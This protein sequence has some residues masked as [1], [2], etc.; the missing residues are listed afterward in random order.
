MSDV[1]LQPD[2]Q[3]D[4]AAPDKQDTTAKPAND[5]AAPDKANG[6][7][8]AAGGKTDDAQGAWPTDWRER[9]ASQVGGKDEKAVAKELKRLQRLTDP[10]ALY[11]SYREL[12][13][14]FSE[15]GLVK[16]PGAK[17]T[18][19][20]RAAFNKALGVPERPEDYLTKLQLGDGKVLGDL[21][22]PIAESFAKAMHP[23]GLTPAQMSAAVAWRL[24]EAEREA[25]AQY[26]ADESYRADAEGDLKERWGPAMD[27][28]IRAIQTVFTNAPGGAD[29]ANQEGLMARLLGGRTADGRIIGDDPDI[30]AWLAGLALEID[31]RSTLVPGDT[32]SAQ[33]GRLEEI[34]ALRRS[35]PDKYNADKKMQAEE[36]E[37]IGVELKMKNRGKAA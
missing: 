20:E 2:N 28:N 5:K 7:T 33:M 27:A 17:A 21:D 16:V 15:G 18:D 25:S 19:D 24:D 4:T 14:K 11:G 34:R 29:P 9:M 35:D 30:T 37:L 36:L 1:D 31:P 10:A 22:K 12:D 8:V 13:S 3:P 26:D 6:K 23:L 32:G